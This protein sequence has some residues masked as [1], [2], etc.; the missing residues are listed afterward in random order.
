M[1]GK[2]RRTT[3]T[4]QHQ[5]EVLVLADLL[6]EAIRIEH[7]LADGLRRN[8]GQKASLQEHKEY[9]KLVD[10]LLWECERAVSRYVA[11]IRAA[12]END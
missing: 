5:N 7:D 4:G 9:Q 3:N 8:R 6:K 10:Q 11:K 1:A 12:V 2:K